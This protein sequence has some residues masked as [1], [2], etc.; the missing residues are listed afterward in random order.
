MVRIIAGDQVRHVDHPEY[1]IGRAA[2]TDRNGR[3]VVWMAHGGRWSA[4][5][6]RIKELA[7]V[8]PPEPRQAALDFQRRRG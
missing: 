5:A 8:G 7:R 4:G 3:W 1:G 6:Y 2:Q